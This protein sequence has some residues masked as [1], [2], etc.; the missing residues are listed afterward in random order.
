MVFYPKNA[1]ALKNHTFIQKKFLENLEMS[2]FLYIFA[3][4]KG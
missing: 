1:M 3:L 2:F 4:L